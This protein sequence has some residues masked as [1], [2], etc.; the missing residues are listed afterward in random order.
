M[1]FESLINTK[2]TGGN[3]YTTVS[4]SKEIND[5]ADIICK[6][7]QSS[8]MRFVEL[9]MQKL[10]YEFNDTYG[11]F[12]WIEGQPHLNKEVDND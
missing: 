8:K 3:K 1:T 10:I 6:E 11:S 9:A 7:L 2:R 4:L 12:T 5:K